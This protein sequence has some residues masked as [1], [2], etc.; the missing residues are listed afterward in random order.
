MKNE[1]IFHKDLYKIVFRS[2]I[3]NPK[4]GNNKQAHSEAIDKPWYVYE[5]KY[6]LEIKSNE[7]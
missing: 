4:S 1:Y 7:L 6:Y 3:N 5:V 2:I